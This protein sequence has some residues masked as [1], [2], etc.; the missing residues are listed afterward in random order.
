MAEASDTNS[1]TL[2][3]CV[4]ACIIASMD[5]LSEDAQRHH[6]R[7][8]SGSSYVTLPPNIRRGNMMSPLHGPVT[9]ASRAMEFECRHGCGIFTGSK[10]EYTA[11]LQ[12]EHGDYNEAYACPLC[13]SF[14]KKSEK[15]ARHMDV[16][17]DV[18][19][20]FACKE[21]GC[22]EAFKTRYRLRR[23]LAHVH[24]DNLPFKCEAENCSWAFLSQDEL[25]SHVAVHSEDRPFRCQEN[26]CSQRFK[27]RSNLDRHSATVH[28]D[29]RPFRCEVDGCNARFKLQNLLNAH[30][31]VH[32]TYKPFADGA[33]DPVGEGER[34]WPCELCEHRG[35]TRDELKKHRERHL[36]GPCGFATSVGRNGTTA[37]ATFQGNEISIHKRTCGICKENCEFAVSTALPT[38]KDLKDRNDKAIK[39]RAALKEH[40]QKHSTAQ[41]KITATSP[42]H[43]S[44]VTGAEVADSTETDEEGLN[45]L[46]RKRDRVSTTPDTRPSRRKTTDGIPFVP[47]S[48]DDEPSIV[49][50]AN[51]TPIVIDSEDDEPSVVKA[52]DRTRIVLD[53]EDDEE[54]MS[55]P[56]VKRRALTLPP[57]RVKTPSPPAT[58]QAL[59]PCPSNVKGPSVSVPHKV[60]TKQSSL[61]A[62]F[63]KADKEN[64]TPSN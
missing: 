43:S 6:K 1:S 59:L 24:C 48:E 34:N 10:R 8:A 38:L 20:S 3:Y 54:D 62:F 31:H 5:L 12:T 2:V 53:S 52:T 46:I 40:A 16:H 29:D 11:H 39:W 41:T 21:D 19:R 51:S 47:D 18:R 7:G 26:G 35:R 9:A 22:S 28:S 15:L 27:T 50:A 45:H 30:A 4:E 42:D 58:R 60:G 63:G 14:F 55:P 37:R 44:N 25:L 13:P 36:V 49:K 33:E 23:H 61:T 64:V 57:S 17:S 56:T 32:L